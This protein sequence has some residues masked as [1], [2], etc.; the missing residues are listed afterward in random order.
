MALP[1]G[2]PPLVSTRLS[3]IT[4]KI[5]PST[6][7][8]G[9]TISAFRLFSEHF[10]KGIRIFIRSTDFLLNQTIEDSYTSSLTVEPL[11]FGLRVAERS[12]RPPD[13]RS[14]CSSTSPLARLRL[15]RT[16]S[17]F[18]KSF[19]LYQCPVVRFSPLELAVLVQ[20][21]SRGAKRARAFLMPSGATRA[22]GPL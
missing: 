11:S 16:A 21:L 17:V 1:F 18:S 20:K 3:L 2:D 8:Y 10:G 9:K 7:S 6:A 22:H 12:R 19:T 13:S 14:A 15:E 4:N 5:M